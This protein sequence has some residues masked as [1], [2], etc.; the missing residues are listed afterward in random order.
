MPFFQNL[1]LASNDVT[2]VCIKLRRTMIDKRQDQI[3]DE[4]Y[5]YASGVDS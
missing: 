3:L 2:D 4:G 1:K 5:L